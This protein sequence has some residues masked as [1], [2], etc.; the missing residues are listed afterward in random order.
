MSGQSL[1]FEVADD[2]GARIGDHWGEVLVLMAGI[3][4]AAGWPGGSTSTH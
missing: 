1:P 4:L 2:R 3:L